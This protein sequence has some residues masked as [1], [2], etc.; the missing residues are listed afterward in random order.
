LCVGIIRE[1][2]IRLGKKAVDKL[3]NAVPEDVSDEELDFFDDAKKLKEK[4][5]E[6]M[7]E[8]TQDERGIAA[9]TLD[10]TS[11]SIYEFGKTLLPDDKVTEYAQ[12]LAGTPIPT[13]FETIKNA[14]GTIKIFFGSSDRYAVAKTTPE[15]WF[16]LWKE[17]NPIT[18]KNWTMIN[19]AIL[20]ML[21]DSEK[22]KFAKAEKGTPKPIQLLP[23]NNT[24]TEV[25][26]SWTNPAQKTETPLDPKTYLDTWI[27]NNGL[28]EGTILNVSGTTVTSTPATPEQQKKRIDEARSRIAPATLSDAQISLYTKAGATTPIPQSILQTSGK[29][30]YYTV[31]FSDDPRDSILIQDWKNW[32]TDWVRN[33]RYQIGVEN[34]LE[35]TPSG[36]IRIVPDKSPQ[37]NPK[38]FPRVDLNEVRLDDSTK[39]KYIQAQSGTPV[40]VGFV[41]KGPN[42][43]EVKLSYTDPEK[44]VIVP[45]TPQEYFTVWLSNNNLPLNQILSIPETSGTVTSSPATQDEALKWQQKIVQ[46]V[47][48]V[49]QDVR[50]NVQDIALKYQQNQDKSL[51][52]WLIPVGAVATILLVKR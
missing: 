10:E 46:K 12:G 6:S 32:L 40:P 27:I 5:D 26:F 42:S 22:K 3:K 35:Y 51:P 45:M 31:R 18:S 9:L 34:T 11:K 30:G 28:P 37:L 52:W 36:N 1:N 15:I 50:S 24:W 39:N 43:Y 44:N 17:N 16:E 25:R 29:P 14:G 21:T 49:K 8:A 13:G 48:A 41:Q 47:G 20:Q 2:A 38:E 4:I 7:T 23:I 33:N 19:G